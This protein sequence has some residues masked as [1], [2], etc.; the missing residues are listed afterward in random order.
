MGKYRGAK[1][2]V[3]EYFNAMENAKV[4]DVENIMKQYLS[5]EY[6]WKAS[7]PF[8]DLKGMEEVSNNFWIPLKESL[9]NMQRRMDVFIG[10]TNEFNDEI[11]VMCMGHFM[12]LF[13]KDFL[14]IRHTK[15]MVSLRFA[16]FN[17]V[18]DGKIIKTG[19]FF[20]LIGLMMQAGMNPLP[21]ST[22]E[23]FIY[24]GPRMHDGLLFE[25][26]PEEEGVKTLAVIYE[27]CDVLGKLNKL[28]SLEPPSVEE[29]SKSWYDNMIWYGPAGIG[30]TYTISR[31][32]EQHSGPFRR[33]L[34]D[35][36]FNGHTVRLAEGNFG[37]FFGWPNLSNRP[38]G[39]F[40]GM[41]AGEKPAEMMVVDVY[42]R[43]GDKLSE[44][45]VIID[46]PYW[47]KQQGLDILE[48]TSSILN[49]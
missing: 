27:M 33:G 31:Y 3:L 38:V 8:R 21:P 9:T 44:N 2:V 32:I 34:G 29:L 46:L 14:G 1:S 26:A 19:L 47:L 37:C 24:P 23:Y 40:L 48:R 35:K 20:D 22:G 12:G 43:R 4:C 25:D 6:S 30:A 11:W 5:E 41:T 7:Y 49:C 18:K 13:D 28:G 36:I 17:C 10:G 45:W 16:E 42:C 39:G 15:K